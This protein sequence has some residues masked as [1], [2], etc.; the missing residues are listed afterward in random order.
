MAD[1]A[2]ILADSGMIAVATKRKPSTVRG[3]VKAGLIERKGTDD[4]RRALFDLDEAKALAR[5][6]DVGDSPVGPGTF[7]DR[8]FE[9]ETAAAAVLAGVPVH[10]IRNWA[11]RGYLQPVRSDG[12]KTIYDASNVVRTAARFGYLSELREREAQCIAPRCDRL[13]W[14]DVQVPLCRQ[15][16]VAVWVHV[17]DA[18]DSEMARR[19][20]DRG[21][22]ELSRQPVVYFIRAGS[23]VKIGTTVNLAK[24]ME[25]LSVSSPDELEILLL[26]AGS[27]REEDQVHALFAEDRIRGEWFHASD[28]LLEFIAERADQD[29]RNAYRAAG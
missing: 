25:A 3:W 8:K 27:Y 16:S 15:H 19:D 1:H 28:R 2:V 23:R 13:A 26:V 18:L 29:L 14:P 20:Q 24:R 21:I 22:A 11:S 12:T 9:V 17:N 10:T 4:R 5:E 6:L 7:P